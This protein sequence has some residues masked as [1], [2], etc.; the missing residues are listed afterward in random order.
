MN[1]LEVKKSLLTF[2]NKNSK[3]PVPI[4]KPLINDAI[5]KQ[6]KEERMMIEEK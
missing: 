5:E 1:G 2:K 3:Q 4:N 6:E